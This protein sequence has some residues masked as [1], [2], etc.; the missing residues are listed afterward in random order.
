MPYYISI[1]CG[2][3]VKRGMGVVGMFSLFQQKFIV[4]TCVGGLGID[5][6]S[7]FIK[8]DISKKL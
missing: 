6:V 3:L 2:Y 1:L 7:C 5:F 8:S 4:P